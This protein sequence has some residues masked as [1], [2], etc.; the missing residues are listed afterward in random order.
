M[1]S[2]ILYI[3]IALFILSGLKVIK[4]YERSVLFTLGKYQSILTPGLK[5]VIP[6]IQSHQRV[7]LRIKTID[8]RSQEAI[9]KDNVSVKVNAVLY[10]KIQDP[11][12]AIIEVEHYNYAVSQ[13]AQTTMRNIVG[14]VTLDELL[15][16]REKISK[17]KF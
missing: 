5:F 16:Q 15:A 3:I 17:K 12:R 6:I 7:D 14:E 13:L 9:T 11:K 1:I 4:E 10:Y 8:V 2:Y